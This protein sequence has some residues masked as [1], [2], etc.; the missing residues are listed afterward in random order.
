MASAYDEFAWF[1][2]RY[3]AAPFHRWQFPALE[4]LLLSG[5]NPGDRVLDL[6]CGSGKLSE[7]LAHRGLHVTGV[8]SS[9]EM[10]RLARENVPSGEFIHADASDFQLERCVRAA[11]CS[12]DSVNHILDRDQLQR[13]FRNVYAVLES[14]GCFVFDMNTRSAYGEHWSRLACEVQAGDAFFLRGAFDPETNT[15]TTAITMFRLIE[16]WRRSDVEIRQRPWEVDEIEPMLRTAGFATAT[17]HR[18]AELGLGG[19]YAAGR[20]FLRTFK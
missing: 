9:G 11:V 8:D 20:F 15:G 14:N 1:Y 7:I 19:H 3:W 5:L 10:L 2:N 13:A 4:R 17:V 12:S 16:T 6:C 18:P